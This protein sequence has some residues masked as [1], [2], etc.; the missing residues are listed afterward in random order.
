MQQSRRERLRGNGVQLYWGLAWGCCA[1]MWVLL[2][3]QLGTGCISPQSSWE[4]PQVGLGPLLPPPP[5]W[6]MGRSPQSH[7]HPVC[8][9][10]HGELSA[11]LLLPAG[12]TQD[13]PSGSIPLLFPHGNPH[14]WR[15]LPSPPLTSEITAQGGG[16]GGEPGPTAVWGCSPACSRKALLSGLVRPIGSGS[17]CLQVMAGFD[18]QKHPPLFFFLFFSSSNRVAFG[19]FINSRSNKQ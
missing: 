17:L 19:L 8:F 18:A 16:V 6:D 7:R 13:D 5:A 12:G 15:W 9:S 14:S 11:S 3:P 4:H 10:S 1:C 2:L